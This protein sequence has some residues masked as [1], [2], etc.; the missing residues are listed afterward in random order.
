MSYIE[1]VKSMEAVLGKKIEIQ[2]GS[3]DQSVDGMSQVLFG[4][5]GSEQSLI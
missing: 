2:E 5:G 3:Y 1:Y 4:T